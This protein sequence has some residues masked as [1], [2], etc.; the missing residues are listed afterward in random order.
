MK[1]KRRGAIIWIA[2]TCIGS[3]II[4]LPIALANLGVLLTAVLMGM[5]W[6]L[7]YYTSLISIELNLQAGEG[8]ALGALARKFSG[9]KAEWSGVLSIKLLIYALLSAYI[10]GGSDI[11]HKMLSVHDF[12]ITS[13]SFSETSFVYTVVT[14]VI[15]LLPM[16]YL[17]YLNRFLFLGLMGVIVIVMAYLL[18]TLHPSSIPWFPSAHFG[19]HHVWVALPILFTSFGFQVIFHTL[20]DYCEKNVAVLKTAF[21]WG[22]L[23]PALVY[24]FWTTN[25]L[26]T[27]AH[28]DASFFETMLTR[29]VNPSELIASI[30]TIAQTESTQL[31]IWWITFLAIYTSV[32]GIGVGLRDTWDPILKNSI[33]SKSLRKA[34]SIVVTMVPPFLVT[35]FVPNAF[36]TVLS[37]AGFVLLWIAIGLPM[38]L[39]LSNSFSTIFYPELISR[40]KMTLAGIFGVIIGLAQILKNIY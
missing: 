19:I 16:K 21:F 6:W 38:V 17:D 18:V 29:I 15:L 40:P 25:V 20:T 22:S 37:I 30:V 12:G 11:I 14:C 33:T 9:K 4:A 39:F 23:I 32:L 27:V 8:L 28:N 35:L 26:S 36:I 1:N 31:L 10:A 24:L 5:M 34:L 2:S 3:G 13:L 7:V